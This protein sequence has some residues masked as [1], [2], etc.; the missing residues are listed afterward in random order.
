[1]AEPRLFADIMVGF[2]ARDVVTRCRRLW[3]TADSP[4]DPRTII[5]TLFARGQLELHIGQAGFKTW[6]LLIQQKGQQQC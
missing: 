2:E 4:A 6:R 3:Q 5:G 1:V